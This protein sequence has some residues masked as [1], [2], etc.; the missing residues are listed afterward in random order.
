[1]GEPEQVIAEPDELEE[2]EG[3]EGLHPPTLQQQNPRLITNAI[4]TVVSFV[5]TNGWYVVGSLLLI[6]IAWV[7]LEPK[8]K[9]W[10]EKREEEKEAA[11]YHKNPDA[12]LAKHQAIDAVRQRMQERYNISAAASLEKKKEREEKMREE[13]IAEWESRQLGGGQRL[14]SKEKSSGAVSASSTSS[15]AKGKP[16]TKPRMRPEYNPLTGDTGASSS[17]RWRPSARGSSGGG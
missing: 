7:R 16:A 5:A 8:F 15:S 4:S 17:S 11:E 3:V 10:L 2:G 6:Y 14:K 9:R 12:L 13:K 1:M